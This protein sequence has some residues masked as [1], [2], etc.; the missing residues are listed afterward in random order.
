MFVRD[1]KEEHRYDS[2]TVVVQVDDLNDNEPILASASCQSISVLENTR[3]D[4]LHRF[5]AYDNDT[6]VNGLVTFSIQGPFSSTSPSHPLTHSML[7]FQAVMKRANFPSTHLPAF[8][9]V[10]RST[11]KLNPPT[12]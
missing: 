11:E 1:A 10:N 4:A 7:L 2:A 5:I 9:R 12:T 6:G 8:S 3:Y